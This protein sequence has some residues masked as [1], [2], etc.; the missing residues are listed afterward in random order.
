MNMNFHGDPNQLSIE[1]A[2]SYLR[3]QQEIITQKLLALD[4][5]CDFIKPPV[6]NVEIVTNIA[7]FVGEEREGETILD[8]QT[9]E[10]RIAEKREVP[11]GGP[12]KGFTTLYGVEAVAGEEVTRAG[13]VGRKDG[14]WV[15]TN[16]RGSK[17]GAGANRHLA[18]AS[19][20]EQ[21]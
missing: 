12:L 15:A 8:V 18:L 6:R 21:D 20:N 7:D 16:T 14:Q 9:V 17:L 3:Q 5:L 11:A 1:D 10:Y 19:F 4:D 13:F 2:R